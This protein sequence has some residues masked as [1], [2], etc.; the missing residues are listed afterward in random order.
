ELNLAQKAPSFWAY[1]LGKVFRSAP[2]SESGERQYLAGI[3]HGRRP[4]FGLRGPSQ[5]ALNFLDGKGLVEGILDLLRL[6]ERIS[7]SAEAPPV[8]HPGRGATVQCDG[9]PLGYLGQ[10]H[11]DICDE[12]GLLPVF[13]FELDFDKLL[14]YAPRQITAHSLP[15]FP[16]VERDFAV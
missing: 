15:R 4:Q 10:M 9:R 12:L 6:S 11:P 7:W 2:D 3:L 16:S 5:P 8:L 1:H 13:V 14:E